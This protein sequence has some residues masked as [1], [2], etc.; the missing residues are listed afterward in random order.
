MKKPRSSAKACG[1]R[2]SGPLRR[3]GSTREGTPARLVAN[4]DHARV[5]ALVAGLGDQ[6]DTHRLL[7]LAAQG[8]P[9][10]ARDAHRDVGAAVAVYLEAAG[11]D[12]GPVLDELRDP[13]ARRG[14]VAVE[15]R[16]DAA[17][18]ADVRP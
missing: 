16:F 13:G 1:S 15:R 4:G 2:S 12:L 18:A 6:L 9:G 3:G 10:G 8:L 11:R 7:G 14:A 17:V 5:G